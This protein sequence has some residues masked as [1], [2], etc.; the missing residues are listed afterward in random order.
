MQ[1]VYNIAIHLLVC[2]W[3]LGEHLKTQKKRTQIQTPAQ[4]ITRAHYQARSLELWGC[5][6]THCPTKH[7]A[8]IPSYYVSQFACLPKAG[9]S[10]LI[11]QDKCVTGILDICMISSLYHP[12]YYLVLITDFAVLFTCNTIQ[13]DKKTYWKMFRDTW[14]NNC[15][16]S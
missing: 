14:C 6:A 1:P 16:I 9:Y 5:N 4:T 13:N 10:P 11:K 8:V 12:N 2:F 7:V 3:E 15:H